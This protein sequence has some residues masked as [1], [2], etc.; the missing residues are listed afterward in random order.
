MS[1]EEMNRKV[2]TSAGEFTSTLKQMAE[3]VPSMV[4]ALLRDVFAILWRDLAGEGTPTTPIRTGR[5]RTAWVLDT[6]ESE[7]VPPLMEDDP[8]SPEEIL[9]AVR[10]AIDALPMSTVYFLYN[11][12]PYILQL[13]RGHSQQAPSGFIAIALA[14]MTQELRRRVTE[15]THA[16]T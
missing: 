12:A 15:F 13:E 5:A 7:W 6:T 1:F 10:Q 4:D 16:H 9:S 11:N 3:L 8:K 14:N 2:C